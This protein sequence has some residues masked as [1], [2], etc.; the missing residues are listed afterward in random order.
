MSQ[1]E[2]ASEEEL[3]RELGSKIELGRELLARLAAPGL[4]TLQGRAK[5][6][7]KVRQ[8]VKFLEKFL[9]PGKL[10]GLKREHI[11]CSNLAHQACLVGLLVEE[12]APLAVL[13]PFTLA[14]EGGERRVVVDIVSDQGNTWVKVVAR[15]PRALA[16]NSQGGAQFGQ[17]CIL[18]QVRD[19]VRCAGQNLVLFAPPTVRFAFANGVT[20]SLR[21]KVLRR[22]AKVGGDLVVFSDDE[23]DDESEVESDEDTGEDEDSAGDEEAAMDDTRVNLDITAMIAYVSALT[24]GRAGFTYRERILSQ[25]AAWERAR[26]V[27]PQLD[28]VFQGKELVCCQSAMSDF[29]AII[30]TL[31]GP[32]ERAR[33]GELVARVTVVPDCLSPRAAGLIDSGKVNARS[34]CIFGTADS[35]RVVTVTANTGFVRAARGQGVA[36]AVTTHESRALTEDKEATATPLLA[37]PGDTAPEKAEEATTAVGENTTLEEDYHEE[38]KV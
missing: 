31:G 26:P 33:A 28:S 20:R 6:E 32:G 36:F 30:A 34:R 23:S 8:E 10:A 16:L 14:G 3:A 12:E 35:L 29:K 22:G 9:A 19:L 15:N 38:V 18:D 27:R 11:G 2:V 25:Q 5:L 21:D 7:K 37:G 13:Q 24:N 17:R 4:A 1:C